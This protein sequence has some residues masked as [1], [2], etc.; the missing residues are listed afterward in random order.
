MEETLIEILEEFNYPIYKQGTMSENEDYPET[1]FTFWNN[2]TYG[3]GYYDDKASRYIWDFDVNVYSSDPEKINKLLLQAK[4]KLEAK[5]FI[6]NEKGH[7]VISDVPTHTGRG[8][9]VQII[10]K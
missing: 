4:E 3:D 5:G 1:F 7:D 8:I 9:D 2:S 6:V 10:E